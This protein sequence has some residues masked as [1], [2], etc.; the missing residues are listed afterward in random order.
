MASI[1]YQYMGMANIF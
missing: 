1:F